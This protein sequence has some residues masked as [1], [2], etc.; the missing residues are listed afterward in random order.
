MMNLR[1][2]IVAGC[3]LLFLPVILL[4]QT[5]THGVLRV[6]DT[7]PDV[8]VDIT[9]YGQPQLRLAELR[10]KLVILDFWG[11]YCKVCIENMPKMEELQRKFGDRIQI[12]LVTD[13]S[14]EAVARL[15]ERSEIVRESTLSSIVGDTVLTRLFEY[16]TVPA[17]A[18]IDEN[19]V[20][21]YFTNG[22]NTTEKTIQSYLDGMPLT[23]ADKGE[24][25]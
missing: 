22:R 2:M 23:L 4:A 15:A 21:Q 7:V 13:D 14:A 3:C 24:R 11:V 5:E 1:K 6:G 20:V 17:H 16:R 25:R 19:G 9:N 10:G 12:L 18:W 8:T